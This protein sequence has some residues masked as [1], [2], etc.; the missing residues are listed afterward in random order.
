MKN[1]KF[2]AFASRALIPLT[3]IMLAASFTYA[4]MVIDDFNDNSLNTALWD[5]LVMGTGSISETDH[6]LELLASGDSSIIGVVFKGTIVGDF[7]VQ[8]DY[9]LLLPMPLVNNEP[10]VAIALGEGLSGDLFFVGRTVTSHPPYENI[11]S[12]GVTGEFPVPTEDMSGTLRFTRVGG[13]MSAYYWGPT[14]WVL[15]D[16]GIT[17]TNPIPFLT[18]AVVSGEGGTVDAAFDNFMLETKA[19]AEPT[20]LLLLGTG[21]GMIGLAAWRRRE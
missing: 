9:Q 13:L 8:A 5:P 20:S 21:L 19:I 2:F 4:D 10:I 16:Q 17:N 1:I 3:L 11:Y 15:L 18:L 6:H 14:D 7:S 12:A